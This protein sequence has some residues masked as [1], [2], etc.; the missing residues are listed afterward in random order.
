MSD[1]VKNT[2]SSISRKEFLIALGAGAAGIVAA[3]SSP[4][5]AF[6]EEKLADSSPFAPADIE[7]FR[8]ATEEEIEQMWEEAVANARAT[9]GEVV[10]NEPHPSAPPIVPY[11][12]VSATVQG[13]TTVGGIPDNVYLLAVYENS[14]NQTRISKVYDKYAY[15]F[16]STCE[17][18]TYSHVIGDGGRTLIVNATVTLRSAAGLAQS[19]RL[20]GE[21]GPKGGNYLT[22]AYI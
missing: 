12:R 21:F 11:N 13:G 10:L 3:A 2:A 1:E 15:G 19:F 22:I 5:T 6:A 9:G 17:H 18:G 16:H 20:H 14:Q 4:D 8:I 7:H